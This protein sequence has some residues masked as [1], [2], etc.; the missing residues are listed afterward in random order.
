MSGGG[1]SIFC[2]SRSRS[3]HEWPSDNRTPLMTAPGNRPSAVC[4]SRRVPVNC[5]FHVER[6]NML[7]REVRSSRAGKTATI[8]RFAIGFSATVPP[9]RTRTTG[10]LQ[11]LQQLNRG[12]F[13]AHVLHIVSL[14]QLTKESRPG[15]LT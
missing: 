14:F 6:L 5:N 4:V 9:I 1:H 12:G 2:I 7:I 11:L 3:V 8:V 15:S 10:L 13:Y